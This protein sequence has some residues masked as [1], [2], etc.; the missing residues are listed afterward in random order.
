MGSVFRLITRIPL[1]G[2]GNPQ[3]KILRQQKPILVVAI[4]MAKACRGIISKPF[5]GGEKPQNKVMLSA[6]SIWVRVILTEKDPK[7]LH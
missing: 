6:N 4:M 3:I 2:I 5:I 1:S 7:R